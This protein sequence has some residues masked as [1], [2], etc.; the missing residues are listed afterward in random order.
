MIATT[1]I[2][3]QFGYVHILQK[4]ASKINRLCRDYLNPY[5]NFHHDPRYMRYPML[6][7]LTIEARKRVPPHSSDWG[8]PVGNQS[9]S[10]RSIASAHRS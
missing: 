6:H 9:S 5:V 1:I 10:P 2:R 7:K 3:K 8:V 4:Y